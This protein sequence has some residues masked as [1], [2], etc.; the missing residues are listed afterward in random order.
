MA[1]TE[2]ETRWRIIRNSQDD[3]LIALE[4]G[5]P[6]PTAALQ[7][8]PPWRAVMLARIAVALGGV[9]ALEDGTLAQIE[10]EAKSVMRNA[11]LEAGQQVLGDWW[12]R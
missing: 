6:L 7:A 4:N 3:C 8:L 1:T 5:S 12:T 9:P 10:G 2:A 11:E